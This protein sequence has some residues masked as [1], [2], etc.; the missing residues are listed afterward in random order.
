MAEALL[1]KTPAEVTRT[2]TLQQ[3]QDGWQSL[4]AGESL[5]FAGDGLVSGGQHID[6]TITGEPKAGKTCTVTYAP[7]TGSADPTVTIEFES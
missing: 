4:A 5:N 7:P 6:P 3:A 1:Q 2:I